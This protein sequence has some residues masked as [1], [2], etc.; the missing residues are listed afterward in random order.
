M[1]KKYKYDAK[2]GAGIPG[3]P[4][5][6]TDEQAAHLGLAELLKEAVKNGAYQE[7][8][9]KPAQVIEK[10]AVKVKEKHDG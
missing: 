5:E 7:I 2:R 9:E 3:L 6:V 4:H 1:P 10:P 8:K